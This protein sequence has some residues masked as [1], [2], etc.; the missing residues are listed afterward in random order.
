MLQHAFS[1]QKPL[2]VKQLWQL[3]ADQTWRQP[4]LYFLIDAAQDRR[5]YPKLVSWQK[6]T[7]I[8]SLYQGSLARDLAEVA[9][10]LFCLGSDSMLFDWIWEQGWGRN[11]GIFLWSR[12]QTVETLRD[13]LRRLTM[14]EMEGS[15]PVM[16]RFYD[17]R[18]LANFLPTCSSQQIAYVFG[19]IRRF[20]VEAKAGAELA[21]FRKDDMGGLT[22]T[23]HSLAPQPGSLVPSNHLPTLV[24]LDRQTAM[25]GRNTAE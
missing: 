9:P 22:R 15:G 1:K 8:M 14:A 19:P 5:I 13:H 18:V 3:T 12:G 21:E 11:W 17:P 24:G 2:V 10:Y 7:E 6:R 4:H 20:A 25:D 16:F 23:V